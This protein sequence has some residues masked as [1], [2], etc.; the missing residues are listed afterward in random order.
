MTTDVDGPSTPIV[1]LSWAIK[2]QF[3]RYIATMTD[4]RCSVTDG[5][6]LTTADASVA[7][8]GR[9]LSPHSRRHDEGDFGRFH[10]EFAAVSCGHEST[11]V[12]F[13][14]D[15]RFSGHH[16]FLFV[17]IAD[18]WITSDRDGDGVLT[19]ACP[20]PTDPTA[21]RLPFARLRLSRP[22][23]H[24]AASALHG[25]EWVGTDVRLTAEGAELFAG[26]YAESEP[27][28]DL[29]LAI[30]LMCADRAPGMSASLVP[31]ESA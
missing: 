24:R 13:H 17:R 21:P 10:F 31:P 7:D 26:A 11:T 19:I 28:D 3:L 30:P 27:L 23:P 25:E 5:A 12:R 29:H 20:D 9:A 6:E 1:G 18:P 2:H 14:G 8:A 22:D 15:V 16:G 4:G